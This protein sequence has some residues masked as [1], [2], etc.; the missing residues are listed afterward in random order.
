MSP[1][2]KD[3]MADYVSVSERIDKFYER[4]PDGSLQAE[5]VLWPTEGFPFIVMKAEASR[6]GHDAQ[7]GVGWA[8]E[9][10]PGT[11]PYTKDSE[12]QNAETS[13]WGRAI[14]A[15]GI[16]TRKGVAT[17]EDVERSSERGAHPAD[18]VYGPVDA[19]GFQTCRVAGCGFKK[20]AAA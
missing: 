12:L 16:E 6:D 1:D 7:P 14:A 18:H 5:V 4:Y 19:E 9:R 8:Q 15:L 10:F 17:A 11:T 13:A 20:K 3:R 2:Y